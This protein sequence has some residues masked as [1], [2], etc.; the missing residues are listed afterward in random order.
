MCSTF[1]SLMTRLMVCTLFT[2]DISFFRVGRT[3]SRSLVFLVVYMTA[4]GGWMV[5]LLTRGGSVFSTLL[6]LKLFSHFLA[7]SLL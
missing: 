4:M 3:F 1:S 7:C 5:V 2:F 6:L